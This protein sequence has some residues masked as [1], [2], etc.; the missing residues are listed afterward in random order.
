MRGHGRREE[1]DS[2]NPTN[3]CRLHTS[4]DL[5]YL[6][7]IWLELNNTNGF[8]LAVSYFPN[9]LVIQSERVISLSQDFPAK[10]D[11]FAKQARKASGCPNTWKDK[12]T[13]FF[14]PRRIYRSSFVEYRTFLPMANSS[15]EVL[16]RKYEEKRARNAIQ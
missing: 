16:T 12:R 3:V 4:G 13:R 8:Y 6:R 1:R 15:P 2:H 10:I 5:L 7:R 9:A 14:Y 11:P